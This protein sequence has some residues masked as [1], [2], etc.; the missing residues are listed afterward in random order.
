MGWTTPEDIAAKVRRRWADGSLL[1]GYADGEPFAPIEVPLRGPKPSQIGDD[2]SA[3]R[4]WVAALDAGRRD[5]TRYTLVW[6]SIGGRAVGRNR[7]PLRAVVSG[8]EQAWVLLGVAASVRRFDGLLA[9]AQGYPLVR[10]WIVDNPH[11]ALDLGS[12]LPQLI[13]AYEWLDT[14]R[15]S[16]R[17]LR[18][19]SAPGVDTK[20]AER[21]RSALAAMLGV[22]SSASGFLSGLG[23]RAKPGLVRLRPAPSLGFPTSLT[24][25]ALR[26]EELARLDVQPGIVIIVENEISYLS[27]EVPDDGVVIWGKGFEVDAVGRLPWLAEADVVY[28]GDIDTHGFAILDRLR[29]WLPL[30]R[31]VLMDRETLLAH[32]DRWVTEDRPA[33]SALTRLATDEQELYADLVSDVLGERVRLEQERIDWGWVQQ[34]L[35]C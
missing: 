16:Q 3:A 34:R 35:R 27:L 33:H 21:H 20:F 18:E 32:C 25:L 29:A 9:L 17:Y 30:A 4:A 28:W 26:S 12:Q 15:G 8:I 7:L 10:H 11:R 19:I 14:N 6:Q 5:D 24:E 23:L 31:S 2:I 13:A 1:R 22:P